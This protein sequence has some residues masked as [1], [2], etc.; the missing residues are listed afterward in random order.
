MDIFISWNWNIKDQVKQLDDLLTSS[1]YTVWRD[2]R[3]L[4]SIHEIKINGRD[5]NSAIGFIMTY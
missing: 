5:Q 4:A 3:D 2:D 1:N